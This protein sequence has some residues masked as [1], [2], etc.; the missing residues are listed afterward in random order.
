MNECKKIGAK[1]VSLYVSLPLIAFVFWEY[2]PI[3]Y[4]HI[5]GVNPSIME[6]GN[7][8]R[9]HISVGP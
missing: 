5:E 7:D 4:L 2:H 3:Y 1:I 9:D 8:L 6:G